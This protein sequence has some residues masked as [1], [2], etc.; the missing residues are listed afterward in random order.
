MGDRRSCWWDLLAGWLLCSHELENV[1][2]PLSDT[3]NNAR[4]HLHLVSAMHVTSSSLLVHSK[5]TT[6]L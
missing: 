6:T 1:F 5:G 3:N 4:L 2:D